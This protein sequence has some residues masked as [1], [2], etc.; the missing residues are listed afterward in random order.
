MACFKNDK[1]DSILHLPAALGHHKLME[2]IISECPFFL[3]EPNWKDQIP[4]HVAAR[5]GCLA[6]VKT[7]VTS[8]AYFSARLLSE[9]DRERFNVYVLKDTDGDTN[10]HGSFLENND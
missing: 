5:A 4:L 8:I 6:V 10:N 1:G 7:L 9:E 2:S 3:L